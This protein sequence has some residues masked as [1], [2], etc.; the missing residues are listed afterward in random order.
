MG[1]GFQFIDIIL[2]AMIAAFLVLRL[3][4]V[5]GRRDG[6]EGGYQDR[7]QRKQEDEAPSGDNVVPLPQRDRDPANDESPEAPLDEE[8]EDE[9]PLGTGIAQIRRADRSFDMD[10]FL[11]GARIAFEMVLGAFAAG[12]RKMLEG[13]LSPEVLGN[14]LQAIDDRERAGETVENTMVGIKAAEAL[15]AY[16]EGDAAHVTVKFQSEQINCTRDE[17]GNTVDGDP[18]QVIEVTDLWTFARDTRSRDPNWSLVA[19]QSLE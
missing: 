12:D 17:D 6:H 8:P 3:R 1:N 4:S 10:E 11:S 5:L 14:F 18:N 13:L 16:M 9:T 19:T 15:E 2:F 7:F